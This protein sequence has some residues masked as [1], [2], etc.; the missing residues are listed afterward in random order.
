M[1]EILKATYSAGDLVFW[2]AFLGVSGAAGVLLWFF[3]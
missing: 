1:I 2:L 3:K